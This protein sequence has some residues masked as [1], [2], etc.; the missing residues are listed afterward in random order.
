MKNI[1]FVLFII[2][3]LVSCT[4]DDSRLDQIDTGAK[5]N[6]LQFGMAKREY[7]VIE[8]D[9]SYFSVQASGNVLENTNVVVSVAGSSFGTE[10][11]FVP[12]KRKNGKGE[13]IEDEF[14]YD[15][16]SG[17]ITVTVKPDKYSSSKDYASVGIVCIDDVVEDAAVSV[18]VIFTIEEATN[19]VQKFW[20]GK[21]DKDSYTLNLVDNDCSSDLAGN[22]KAVMESSSLAGGE[23]N[24]TLTKTDAKVYL[25]DNVVGAAFG[26]TTK[27]PCELTTACGNLTGKVALSGGN[28]IVV[29]GTYDEAKGKIDLESTINYNGKVY[30]YTYAMTKQ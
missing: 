29:K 27:I 11:K 5:D 17:K 19:S 18:P 16:A 22:Y 21:T 28:S 9:T 25:L 7:S 10:Y 20:S 26:P 6:V 24:V 14:T 23:F 2:V 12:A 4:E 15:A 8:G 30:A 1:L 13:V 3:S